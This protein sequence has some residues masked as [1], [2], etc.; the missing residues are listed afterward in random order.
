MSRSVG[1]D[2]ARAQR[3]EREQGSLL[4]AAH[5]EGTTVDPHLERPE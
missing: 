1:H 2:F 5:L 4:L 3:E